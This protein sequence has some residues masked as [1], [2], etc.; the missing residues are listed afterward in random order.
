MK[1]FA[2]T[3]RRQV[4]IRSP[5]PG[6]LPREWILYMDAAGLTFRRLGSQER[7]RLSWRT[8]LGIGL[9]HNAREI[10]RKE[11]TNGSTKGKRGGV[12]R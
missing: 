10:P 5:D 3:I 7:Y 12:Y 11:P 4:V 1:A 6:L 2:K 8:I 9:V